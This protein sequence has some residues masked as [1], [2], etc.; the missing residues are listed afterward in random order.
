M[1]TLPR[2]R[3]VALLGPVVER[4]SAHSGAFPLD[5]AKFLPLA[6][7]LLLVGDDDGPGAMLFRYTAF[8]E[9][10][11]D[12]WHPSVDDATEQ[13]SDEYGE[14]L[15]EWMNVPDDIADAHHFAIE[16]ARDRLND[17]ER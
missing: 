17:R 2:I 10:G 9:L 3:R 6:D 5:S 16:Y 13:A 11:G 1:P 12:T 14:S 4:R 8:G 15:L 7:V